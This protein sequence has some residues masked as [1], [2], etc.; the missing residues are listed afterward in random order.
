LSLQVENFQKWARRENQEINDPNTL[1]KPGYGTAISDIGMK[2][3][4]DD[5]MNKFISPI[6]KGLVELINYF[7]S[8]GKA[9][10]T[11]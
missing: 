5:L 9:S 2:G 11:D 3:M 10:Y 4:L 7:L 1:N 8:K 6:S